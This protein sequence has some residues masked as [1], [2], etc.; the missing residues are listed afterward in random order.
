MCSI[1]TN[2]LQHIAYSTLLQLDQSYLIQSVDKAAGRLELT[3]T[4]PFQFWGPARGVTRSD[5][6]S[7][8]VT[9]KLIVF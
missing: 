7:E 6:I 1:R 9:H 2:R 5:A 3:E 8:S 4:F